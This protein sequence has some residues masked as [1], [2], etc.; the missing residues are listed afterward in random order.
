MLTPIDQALAAI[1]AEAPSQP[2]ETIAVDALVERVCAQTVVAQIDV[3]PWPNSAMDGYAVNS[4][5]IS[6]GKPYYVSQKIF[7]GAAPQPLQSGTVARI[8]TGAP[9]PALADAVIMQE[10]AEQT[11]DG[12][13][14]KELPKLGQHIRAQ[15]QDM[16]AGQLL[17]EAG[18]VFKAADIAVLCSVGIETVA[19]RVKPTVVVFSSGDELVPVG[20]PLATGQIYNSNSAMLSAMLMELGCSVRLQHTAADTLNDTKAAL[21]AAADGADLVLS[22]GGVSVGEA[23]YMR[24]ALEEVGSVKLWKL[25]IKPGK[26]LVYGAIQGV[27]YFGLP[28]N[29]SSAF[30]TCLIA[31]LPYLDRMLGRVPTMASRYAITDF[32]WPEAGSRQEYLRVQTYSDGYQQR[33]RLFANQ[34]SGVVSSTSWANALAVIPIGASFEKGT[35]IEVLPLPV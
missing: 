28:G 6:L 20:Q 15:A 29:P 2:V 18:H 32:D 31:V 3:P 11:D 35:V 7:A 19:V 12:I 16:A 4:A 34:S 26:P 8:F 5:E 17:F 24:A 30:V 10:D 23:D 21:L 1:L 22:T 33:V 13:L 27:P 25:A 14:F 9:M